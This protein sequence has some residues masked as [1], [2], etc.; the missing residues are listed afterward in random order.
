MQQKSFIDRIDTFKSS[1]LV[2]VEM[3]DVAMVYAVFARVYLTISAH[4]QANRLKRN[5]TSNTKRIF[6]EYLINKV[7]YDVGCSL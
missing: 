1:S 7:I 6:D 2:H 5:S 4:E 3:D